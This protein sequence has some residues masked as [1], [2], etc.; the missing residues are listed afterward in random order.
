MSKQ[1]VA[2]FDRNGKSKHIKICLSVVH[3]CTEKGS[4]QDG[5][6]MEKFWLIFSQKKHPIV[7]DKSFQSILT[8]PKFVPTHAQGYSR[9]LRSQTNNKTHR[10]T[11]PGATPS[12]R[13]V[14][15]FG[16]STVDIEVDMPAAARWD[17]P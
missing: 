11:V 14:F 2:R 15:D 16:S 8:V 6:A 7:V 9:S 17:N 1:N 5:L 13:A 12:M 4:A 10:R 3:T